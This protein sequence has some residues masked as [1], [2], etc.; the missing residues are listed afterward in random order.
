M[1][2]RQGLFRPFAHPLATLS[3]AALLPFPIENGNWKPSPQG[4]Y[5][6]HKYIYTCF[7]IWIESAY[8]II[9]YDKTSYN[10]LLESQRFSLGGSGFQ[11]S[12]LKIGGCDFFDL[13]FG[14]FWGGSEGIMEE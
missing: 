6:K 9:Q 7:S 10:E 5:N 2:M 3:K 11:G 14:G 4:V 8:D 12:C 1:L 13:D